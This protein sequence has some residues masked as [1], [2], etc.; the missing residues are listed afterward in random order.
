M[1]IDYTRHYLK[2]HSDTPEH[3][4]ATTSFY[5]RLL[6]AHLPSNPQAKMLDVG[7]GMG[8]ALLALKALGYTSVSGIDCDQGQIV[9]CK[10]KGLDVALSSDTV[11]SLKEHPSNFDVILCLDV[12]EHIP[13]EK[14]LEFVR[15]L[16]DALVPSGTLICTMPNANSAIASRTRYIDWTHHTSFTEHS[17]DFLLFN[18]GFKEIQIL[19]MEFTQRPRSFWLPFLGGARH[20]WAFRF[21]RFWRRLEMMAELG[22][23]QGRT[24]PL[25]PNLFGVAKK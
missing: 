23:Q 4:S 18:G 3:I 6:K 16:A 12:I 21:F 14:Q 1:K 20:W 10:S 24:V 15:A 19:P 25:S 5:S 17:L 2:W 22:P 7:C 8:F 13:M 11:A 9:S